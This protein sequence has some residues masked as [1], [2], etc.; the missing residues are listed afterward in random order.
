MRKILIFLIG[1]FPIAV[2]AVSY[3]TLNLP[4]SDAPTDLPTAVAVS[5]LTDLEILEG[6]PDGT[7]RP[8]RLLNRAE[9]MTIAMRLLPLTPMPEP[10]QNA[11]D[12]SCFIDVPAG[13]WYASSVCQAKALNIVHGNAVGDDPAQWPFVPERP[14]QY[15]EALKILFGIFNFAVPQGAVLQTASDAWYAVYVAKAQLLNLHL[16][17]LLPGHQLTR[18]EIARL[19]ANFVAYAD[20]NLDILHA[21]QEGTSSSSSSSSSSSASNSTSSASTSSSSSYDPRSDTEVR[22]DFLLLGTTTP[23]LGAAQIFSD[24]EP[25][26]VTT[27][28]IVLTGET[29][30]IQGFLV[31]DQDTRFIGRAYRD[32]SAGTRHYTVDLA[33]SAFVV[34]HRENR[35]VYARAML[36]PYKGGGTSGETVQI[37]SF[38]V[39]GDGVWSHRAY[40]KSTTETYAAYQTSRAR[41]TAIENGGYAEDPLVSGTDLPLGS[42]RFT[43]ELGDSSAD[44][45]VTD[46]AI[47]I[48]QNGGVLVSGVAL[49]SEGISDRFGCSVASSTITCSGIPEMFGSFDD[50]PRTLTFYGDVSVP[51]DALNAWLRL[52][53]NQ[54]GSV[55]SS[56]AMT[57][58]DGDTGFSWV[59]GSSPVAV[60]TSFSR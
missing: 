44:L 17:G 13:A 29:P 19:V 39:K 60:S 41:I 48:E 20:G 25:L 27:I 30:S 38:Q 21:V 37:E 23:I 35:S 8:H 58:T 22:A 26:D 52:K 43:G 32:T 54:A 3:D 6:N 12:L 2:S 15:E 11:V 45:A 47:T 7:F 56:G 42:F 10:M 16:S 1:L 59:Q 33:S 46:L 14:V 4:Y 5:T 24:T 51:D 9:F 50:A 31:Y 34:P 18:G 57:W 49:G 36:N 55:G 40:T 28:T 53:I